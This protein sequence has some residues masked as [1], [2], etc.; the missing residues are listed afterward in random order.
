MSIID[1]LACHEVWLSFL[2]EKVS[3]KNMDKR[4]IEDLTSFIQNRDYLEVTNKI[5]NKEHF[6]PPKKKVVSKQNSAKKRIVYSFSREENYVLKLLTYLLIRQYDHI[7]AKNLYSFRAKHGVKK[8]IN[9]LRGDYHLSDKYVYKVDI[10]DY[11][12]SVDINLLLP[13]L[14]GIMQDET[15]AY[16]FIERLLS[17]PR[18]ELPNRNVVYEKKGIMA[19]AG[20]RRHCKACAA[21]CW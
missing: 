9:Y 3:T 2:E 10:H 7:F 21:W 19:G 16:S 15:E 4:Q 6:L 5:K 20:S 1:K 17:D 12:N 18:V 8:A 13:N 11:F 14:K